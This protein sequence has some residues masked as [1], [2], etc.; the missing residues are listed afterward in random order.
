MIFNWS[1]NVISQGMEYDEV[2]MCL[3]SEYRQK[4][5]KVNNFVEI[6]FPA[7]REIDFKTHFRLTRTSVEVW[8]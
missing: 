7:M 2:V 6:T 8:Y 5:S 1:N 4:L 3:N